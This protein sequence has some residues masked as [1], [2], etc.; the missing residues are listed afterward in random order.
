MSLTGARVLHPDKN[1]D[2]TR[3]VYVAT[4]LLG[5]VAEPGM[6]A[7]VDAGVDVPV[8]ALDPVGTACGAWLPR[9]G[10]HLPP[11]QSPRG[12]APLGCAA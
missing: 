5:L 12:S 4:E 6:A 10:A 1:P 9:A 8:G 2:R 11:A 3:T 7:Y